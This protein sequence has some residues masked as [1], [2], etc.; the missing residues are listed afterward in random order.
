M[1]FVY[2]KLLIILLMLGTKIRNN[3]CLYL[4]DS[5]TWFPKG[6]NGFVTFT[7]CCLV[8]GLYLRKVEIQKA[9]LVKQKVTWSSRCIKI[10]L[11]FMHPDV[12]LIHIKHK[13]KC[14]CILMYLCIYILICWYIKDTGFFLRW[15]KLS[16][17]FHIYTCVMCICVCV[18][19]WIDRS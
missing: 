4:D 6:Q 9:S 18:C 14:V 11:H 16:W 1:L 15:Y 12:N 10:I 8:I 5:R 17:W 3:L 19:G 7:K 2:L 13:N